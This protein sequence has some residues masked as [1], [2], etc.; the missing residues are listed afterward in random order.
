VSITPGVFAAASAPTYR[1]TLGAAVTLST[2][3]NQRDPATGALTPAND[4]GLQLS[5]TAPDGTETV[6]VAAS[7]GTNIV[8]DAPGLYHAVLQ[9]TQIGV[10]SWRW[11]GDETAQGAAEG[12]FEVWSIYVA[13]NTPPDLTDLRVLVPRA[14][15]ACE[16]PYGPPSGRP[17]LAED[18]VYPMV[19]DACGEIILVAGTLFGHELNVTKRDPIVGY[20]T[21]WATDTAL[22]EWES[23]AIIC[24]LGLDYWRFLFRDMKV[25]ET[26]KNEGTEWSYTLSANAIRDYLSYLKSERDLALKAL[27]GFHPIIDRYA[28]NIRV[29]DQ[30]TVTVLEWWSTNIAD[31]VPGLPG[32]QEAAVVPWVPGYPGLR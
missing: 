31:R 10:Y 22:T 11:L 30:A 29:R 12:T 7:D 28:S 21:E 26:I 6:T 4:D 18:V 17:A 5:V 25:S 9:P 2:V 15:R 14:I 19:A 24:Q 1:V 8:N 13:P 20:P 23:A 16:G 32:G 27:Q 3:V